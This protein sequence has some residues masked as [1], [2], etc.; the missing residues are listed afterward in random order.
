METEQKSFEIR[1]VN[2]WSF[3][4]CHLK[5]PLQDIV[6]F[7]MISKCMYYARAKTVEFPLDTPLL[8]NTHVPTELISD[9]SERFEKNVV[10]NH[11]EMFFISS[12]KKSHISSYI[13]NLWAIWW[14]AISDPAKVLPAENVCPRSHSD[15]TTTFI[16][17]E[18]ISEQSEWFENCSSPITLIFN[19]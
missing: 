8:L 10:S 4:F 14:A 15:V 11:A 1:V 6:Q 12:F 7:Q 2:C 18:L 9:Q 19:Q 17:T 5:L 13:I 3:G 16:S